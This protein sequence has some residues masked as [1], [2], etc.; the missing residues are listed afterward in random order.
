MS[1][2]SNSNDFHVIAAPSPK[3]VKKSDSP[4][5]RQATKPAAPATADSTVSTAQTAVNEANKAS[6]TTDADPQQNDTADK[7]NR[8]KVDQVSRPCPLQHSKHSL[9]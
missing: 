9:L 1:L 2:S 5:K 8:S 3:K 7:E 6:Q 4:K